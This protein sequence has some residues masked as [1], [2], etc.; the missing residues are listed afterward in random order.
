MEIRD[1]CLLAVGPLSATNTCWLSVGYAGW[2][3]GVTGVGVLGDGEAVAG[4]AIG[5]GTE[6]GLTT[7]ILRGGRRLAMCGIKYGGRMMGKMTCGAW[8]SNF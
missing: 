1:C 6:G 2:I 4:E 8:G 7:C 3:V 5:A